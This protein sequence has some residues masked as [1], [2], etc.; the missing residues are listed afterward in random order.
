[1]ELTPTQLTVIVAFLTAVAPRLIEV[2][3]SFL[4]GRTTRAH[5]ERDDEKNELASLRTRLEEANRSC[6][7]KMTA[8]EERYRVKLEEMEKR[9]MDTV[10]GFRAENTELLVKIVRLET[11]LDIKSL[12]EK[13]KK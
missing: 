2:A 4:S 1:M 5:K 12:I 7:E 6:N 13:K 9:H 3:W 11:Q 8:L 10:T